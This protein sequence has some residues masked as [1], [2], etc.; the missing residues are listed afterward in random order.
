MAIFGFFFLS[1]G[2]SNDGIKNRCSND[3]HANAASIVGFNIF[4][5]TFPIFT[6]FSSYTIIALTLINNI[7]VLV[8]FSEN[9]RYVRFMQ[10]SLPL[11]AILPPLLIA[12]FTEDVSSIVGFVGS[13][14]GTLIQYVFPTLLVHKSRSYVENNC[15]KPLIQ[16]RLNRIAALKKGTFLVPEISSGISTANIIGSDP[17]LIDIKLINIKQI[18]FRLNPFAS[19]FQSVFWIYFTFIWWFLCIALVTIDHILHH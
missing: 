15:L 1:I 19:I 9:S 6:L 2:M 5:P 8:N 4:L 11:V 18:Y 7:K 12:L 16:S 17:D 10:Y 13:Y 3:N 14:S